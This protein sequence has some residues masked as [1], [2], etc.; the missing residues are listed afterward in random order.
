MTYY[1][2]TTNEYYYEG[3]SMTRV[4]SDGTVFSGYPSAE[5]LEEWGFEEYTP[6]EPVID[7]KAVRMREI[8]EELESMDYLTSKYIDGEDM[9]KYGDWQARRRALRAEY[10]ELENS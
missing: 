5:Q 7:P 10:N 9:T 1:N 6:P 2:P 8:L 4:V 3:T